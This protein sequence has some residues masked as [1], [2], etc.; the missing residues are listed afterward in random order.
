M[1]SF[2][3]FLL[4][5]PTL[6]IG[7]INIG[8]ITKSNTESIYFSHITF[9]HTDGTLYNTISNENAEYKLSVKPGTYTITATYIGYNTFTKK[10]NVTSYITFD[11]IL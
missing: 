6:A 8:G 2:L 3:F 10:L 4:L 9:K 7:Q 11:I 1:K 5:L